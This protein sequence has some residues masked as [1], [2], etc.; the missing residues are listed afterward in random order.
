MQFFKKKAFIIGVVCGVAVA[1]AFVICFGGR[2]DTAAESSAPGTGMP[3]ASQSVSAP[4]T[5]INGT[6]VSEVSEEA[7]EE[8]SAEVSFDTSVP[9]VS[10]EESVSEVSV[11]DTSE[12]DTSK[13]DTSVPET[14]VPEV[15]VPETSVPEASEPE[16]SVNYAELIIGCW[17]NVER[18]EYEYTA[19]LETDRYYFGAD[20]SGYTDGY[21]YTYYPDIPDGDSGDGWSLAGMGYVAWDF[22]YTVEGNKIILCFPPSGTD[23]AEPDYSEGFT[24]EFTVFIDSEGFLTINSVTDKKY[25]KGEYT[26]KEL[27]GILGVDYTVKKFDPDW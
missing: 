13:P 26:L 15:S 20:G 11:P 3:E 16:P 25:A 24:A 18:I 14:S 9:E 27:C 2:K 23:P 21:T 12:P 22:T 6:G 10:E 7:P 19:N 8:T 17:T 5:S 4:E 1:L